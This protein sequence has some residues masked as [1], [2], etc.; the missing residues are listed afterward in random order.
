[1]GT[2]M[3]LLGATL[4]TTVV[5]AWGLMILVGVVHGVWIVALPTIGFGAAFALVFMFELLALIVGLGC[6]AVNVIL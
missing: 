5:L 1:M 2:F 6:L 4:L 3:R